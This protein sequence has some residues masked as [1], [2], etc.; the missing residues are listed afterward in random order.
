MWIK[1]LFLNMILR[2]VFEGII[3]GPFPGPTPWPCHAHSWQ[4]SPPVLLRKGK[5]QMGTPSPNLPTLSPLSTVSF[6][7][8]LHNYLQLPIHCWKVS[9]APGSLLPRLWIYLFSAFQRPSY[10]LSPFYPP[11]LSTVSFPSTFKYLSNLQF[12]YIYVSSLDLKLPVPSSSSCFILD[13][14][15]VPEISC[16]WL[17]LPLESGWIPAP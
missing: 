1:G 9:P 5:P 15:Y 10:P 3:L 8:W 17:Q 2:G 12:K 11:S 13:P 6:I 7:H 4:W 14:P 16:P